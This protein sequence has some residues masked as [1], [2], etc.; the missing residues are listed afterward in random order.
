MRE[1]RVSH[2]IDAS[3]V[4]VMNAIW[5]GAEWRARWA[6]ITTFD[7]EYD[8]GFHQ[9]AEIVLD[10]EGR[11]TQ[12]QVVRFRTHPL[13]IDFFCPRPPG[14]L[15]YQ[16]GRWAI[17]RVEWKNFVVASRRFALAQMPDEAE[18]AFRL[19]L[20]THAERLSQR[21]SLILSHFCSGGGS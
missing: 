5:S 2:A 10:W 16:S 14:P 21:L 4:D 19:R 9:V 12:M 1:L 15:V 6:P 3:P 13:C 18:A 20:D 7:V 17:E 11:D 8:D